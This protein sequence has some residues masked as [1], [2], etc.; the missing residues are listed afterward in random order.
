MNSSHSDYA[1]KIKQGMISQPF[2]DY[3]NPESR[4]DIEGMVAPQNRGAFID[5]VKKMI[6]EDKFRDCGFRLQFSNDYKFVHKQKH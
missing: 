1:E 2:L 4:F 5:E 3:E 6:D